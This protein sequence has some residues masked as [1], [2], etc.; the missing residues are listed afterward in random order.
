MVSKKLFVT[1]SAGDAL[2][3]PPLTL[4]RRRTSMVTY[5]SL[6][7]QSPEQ[8]EIEYPCIWTYTVIGEDCSLLKDCIISA[9]APLAV[10]I[11]HSRAS[12]K[13]KYHSLHAEIEVP[14]E[15]IRLRIY[16]KLKASLAVK[17]IL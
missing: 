14:S 12:S 10:E 7:G 9:C 1:T 8:P 4:R 6:P 2:V 17:I 15:E 5:N 16:Q 11:T 13:G 3:C